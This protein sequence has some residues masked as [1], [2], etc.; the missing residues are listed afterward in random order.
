MARLL[1][2]KGWSN[3]LFLTA[4]RNPQPSQRS[5]VK[6]A[7]PSSEDP[8]YDAQQK[9]D[10][11][12]AIR[13][14]VLATGNLPNIEL[15]ELDMLTD[16]YRKNIAKTNDDK[17]KPG[18]LHA[19]EVLHRRKVICDLGAVEWLEEKLGGA[20]F[21][22]NANL[23]TLTQSGQSQ[24]DDSAPAPPVQATPEAVPEQTSQSAV[25]AQ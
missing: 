2:A 11:Q 16:E 25:M 7:R 22:Q 21:H 14:F 23:D 17:K 1:G 8:E 4:P 9:L 3:A 15:I 18:E 19:Y 12:Q 5:R 13:N 10:H 20:I 24:T 6:E